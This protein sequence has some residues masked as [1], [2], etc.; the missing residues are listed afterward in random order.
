MRTELCATAS[1]EKLLR[2][3]SHEREAE[4]PM[5]LKE[6][7]PS[8]V[9][10]TPVDVSEE[11]YFPRPKSPAYSTNFLGLGDHGPTY[12]CMSCK[13]I[14]I[15]SSYLANNVSPSDAITAVLFICIRHFYSIS[16][17]QYITHPACYS[18]GT[19]IRLIPPPHQTI[20]SITTL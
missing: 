4:S 14:T 20:L 15:T 13:W 17:H 2:M 9:E 1:P 10:E 5:I 19:S 18:V 8:P 11:S 16:H 7:D 3:A 12:Y 6:L